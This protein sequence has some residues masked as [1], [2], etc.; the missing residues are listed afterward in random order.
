MII[1]VGNWVLCRTSCLEV[2]RTKD[3]AKSGNHFNTFSLNLGKVRVLIL[4]FFTTNAGVFL[5]RY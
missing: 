4:Y 1:P 5:K 3:G 2:S